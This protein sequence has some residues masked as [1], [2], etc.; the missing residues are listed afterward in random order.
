M[1]NVFSEKS[2]KTWAD[3]KDCLSRGLVDT[4]ANRI[5]Y[6]VFQAVK[7]F[8]IQRGLWA[9]D[10]SD[11]VHGEA[12]KIVGGQGGKSTFYRRRLNELLSLRI[13]ADYKLES[14]N[15][16]ELEEL[17]EDADCIRKHHIR[18]AGGGK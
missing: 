10:T 18:V 5:Y 11:G 7:G 17:L 3:G 12:L 8:A 13:I 15:Q 1:P 14:V 9:M 2:A 6:S 16:K 4:A